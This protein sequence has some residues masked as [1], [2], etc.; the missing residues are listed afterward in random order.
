MEKK[1]KLSLNKVLEDI[2]NTRFTGL[3]DIKEEVKVSENEENIEETIG[4]AVIQLNALDPLEM[5][6]GYTWRQLLFFLDRYIYT[7]NEKTE[8]GRKQN[9]KKKTE[10]FIK[11]NKKDIDEGVN[12]ILKY[13]DNKK[14]V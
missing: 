3:F 1:Y 10:K 2:K 13:L 5:L 14:P 7:E 9:E 8:D 12:K 6:K 4:N 11:E